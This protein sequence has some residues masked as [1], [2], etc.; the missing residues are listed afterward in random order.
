VTIRLTL[1]DYNTFRANCVDI[2]VSE[3]DL[4][5][6]LAEIADRFLKPGWVAIMTSRANAADV[7]AA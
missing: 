7:E 3:E 4:A 1:V 2:D 6:S 5:C